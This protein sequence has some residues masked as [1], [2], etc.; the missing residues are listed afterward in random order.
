M[1]EHKKA[2][3]LA[4]YIEYLQAIPNPQDIEVFEFVD[5]FIRYW[6]RDEFNSRI[7]DVVFLDKRG[8]WKEFEEDMDIDKDKIK[9]VIVL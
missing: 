6:P 7:V 8:E 1:S 4:E 9:R 3:T 5:E 2:K